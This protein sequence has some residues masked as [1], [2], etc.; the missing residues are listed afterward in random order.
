MT[1]TP[2]SPEADA[3]MRSRDLDRRLYVFLREELA[4]LVRFAAERGGDRAVLEQVLQP[5]AALLRHTADA[6]E[7]D[8]LDLDGA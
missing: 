6:L 1:V 2:L 3:Y 8:V 7:R 4:P 5:A